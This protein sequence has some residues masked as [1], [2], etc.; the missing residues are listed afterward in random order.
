MLSLTASL[1][2]L[3]GA[4]G[5]RLKDGSVDRFRPSSLLS[6]LIFHIALAISF[7][8][9]AQAGERRMRTWT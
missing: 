7:R 2:M 1:V 8:T 5:P 9:I 4:A 6:Y 3:V